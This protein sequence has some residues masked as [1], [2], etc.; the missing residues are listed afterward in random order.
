VAPS[1]ALGIDRQLPL[2][3]LA[4]VVLVAQ[5]LAMLVA[6]HTRPGARAA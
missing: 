1:V 4:V 3:V 2:L 5:A 6:A